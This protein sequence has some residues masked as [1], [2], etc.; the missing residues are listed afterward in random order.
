MTETRTIRDGLWR[1]FI[2]VNIEVR[3]AGQPTFV[4][5]LKAAMYQHGAVHHYRIADADGVLWLCPP[6][7]LPPDSVKLA[8][9]A[10]D[11]MDAQ[12]LHL[13]RTTPFDVL[14]RAMAQ[15]LGLPD[16]LTLEEMTVRLEQRR[17]EEVG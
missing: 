13:C 11:R 5:A 16:G 2:T 17:R 4:G 15:A 7:W 8:D 14:K 3:P 12:F 9:A 1:P 10:M 6:A